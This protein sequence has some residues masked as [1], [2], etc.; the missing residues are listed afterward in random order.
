LRYRRA[1][2]FW[3]PDRLRQRPCCADAAKI[4]HVPFTIADATTLT[5]AGYVGEDVEKSILRVR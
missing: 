2:S 4:L 1:T 5:E 3:W